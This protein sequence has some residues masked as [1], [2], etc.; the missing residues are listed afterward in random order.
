MS[1]DRDF[2]DRV[3]SS[4]QNWTGENRS[5]DDV[6][7]EFHLYGGAKRAEALDLIDQEFA[8]ADTSDLRKYSELV[9]MRREMKN[10]HHTLRKAGR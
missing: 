2:L 9:R 1:D 7:G 3:N 8:A 10:I 6:I 4:W 5:P